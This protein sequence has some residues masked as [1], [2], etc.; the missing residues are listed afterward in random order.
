MAKN[1]F[2]LCIHC[3][4]RNEA[5]FRVFTKSALT[6]QTCDDCNMIIDKY[7]EYDFTTIFID[8]LLLKLSAY[9]H[10]LYNSNTKSYL[11]RL[12]ALTLLSFSYVEWVH[13]KGKKE[14][15]SEPI[16]YELEW[17][18]YLIIGQEF[19]KAAL[20]SLTFLLF[21]FI[22]SKLIM[23]QELFSCKHMLHG[24]AMSYCWNLV[25]IPSL[26]WNHYSTY[27]V[28]SQI[29]LLI[30]CNHTF[31]VC[32]CPSYMLSIITIVCAWGVQWSA[33]H[34]LQRMHLFS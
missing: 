18:Y 24:M 33:A 23:Q 19:I 7:V 32:I 21:G 26:V 14:H 12:V 22:S 16:F 20:F 27:H 9:R 3:G 10:V 30:S 17:G 15:R 4:A 28:L 6:L 11:S 34:G 29:A 8:I 13:Q 31:H 2:Y 25:T 1:H 5:L